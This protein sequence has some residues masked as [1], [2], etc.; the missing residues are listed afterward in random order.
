MSAPIIEKLLVLLALALV[1]LLVNVKTP[2][3]LLKFATY[4]VMIA[5]LVG[6]TALVALVVTA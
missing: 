2:P 5:S 4:W 3:S 1:M 6:A